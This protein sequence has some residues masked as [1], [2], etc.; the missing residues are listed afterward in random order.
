MY[1]HLQ[2]PWQ[3][4]KERPTT[5][6]VRPLFVSKRRRKSRSDSFTAVSTKFRESMTHDGNPFH[7]FLALT[8]L[9]K[10]VDFAYAHTTDQS[11]K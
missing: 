9:G 8:R 4:P 6:V 1:S 5:K 3:N 11:H 10:Q 2:N 7:V